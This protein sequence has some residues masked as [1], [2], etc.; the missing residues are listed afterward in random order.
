MHLALFILAGNLL[1]QPTNRMLSPCRLPGTTEAF[2]CGTHEVYEDRA[3]RAG[4]KIPLRIVVVPAPA[5]PAAPDPVFFL[6]GGPGQAATTTAINL[7]GRVWREERDIVLVDARGTGSSN[8]LECP[9][10]GNDN[11]V[12]T[13]LRSAFSAELA[14]RCREV[15]SQRADLRL[16]TN[17]EIVDD[18][19]EIRAALGYRTINLIGVSGGTRTAMVYLQRHPSAIRSVVMSGVAPFSAKNP[20]FHAASAQLAFDRLVAACE[21]DAF[22]RSEYPG[23]ADKL[24]RVI[25]RLEREPVRVSIPHPTSGE[26]VEV[27][28][29]ADVFADGIRGIMYA[30][31]NA[32]FIP[33]LVDEAAKG[34][35]RPIARMTLTR[36]R[37]L[38]GSIALGSL[39]S[40]VC[41][42]DVA[43]IRPDEIAAATR[44]TYVGDFRVR[45]QMASCSEWPRAE[46]KASFEE[47]KSKV[48]ALLISGRYDPVTPQQWGDSIAKYMPNAK[49]VVF[50]AAHGPVNECTERLTH[51]LLKSGSSKGLDISCVASVGLPAFARRGDLP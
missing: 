33:A 19:D 51:D 47:L 43:R 28:L 24:R 25:T 41:N 5:R 26:D 13:Y 23:L 11:D 10:S 50:N 4:R 9:E 40:V 18:L 14:R 27:R 49:H 35:F 37:N 22:C 15:L 39:L 20:L 21:S 1:Q 3:R 30:S 8:G 2:L 6:V 42:E 32:R 44:N 48:P 7:S 29:T 16:Y 31:P 12:Q 34:N 38:R 17:A 46:L 36:Y 45:A